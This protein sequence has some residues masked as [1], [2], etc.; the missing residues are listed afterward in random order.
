M[1][2][3]FV[4]EHRHLWPVRLLCAVL[5]ISTSG[6]YAWR[7]SPESRRRIENRALLGDIR[8]VHAESGG[9]YGYPRI[10]AA[11]QSAGRRVGRHRIARLMRSAG[12]RGLVAIPRR[13]RTTDSRHDFPIAPNRLRRNFTAGAPNQVWLA[14]LTYIR[15]GEGWLFLAAL[16]DMYTRKVVGWSMRET[17]HASI[18]LE[19]LRMAVAR[20]RPP[21]G[22]IHHSDLGIQGGFKWSSQHLVFGGCDDF[23]KAA[24]TSIWS[25]ALAVT[26]TA[27]C[28]SALCGTPLTKSGIVAEHGVHH[29]DPAPSGVEP[30]ADPQS[31]PHSSPAFRLT[32]LLAGRG[33]GVR[34]SG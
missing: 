10:H 16:I 32:D 19:A 1:T 11:L 6:Y 20:Q 8:R 17:L 31:V 14:D 2:F 25:G 22:L 23:S 3:G 30:D 28:H 27:A 4:D 9:C 26:R 33:G 29:R 15:T 12:L 7:R 13:V 5:G 21:P 24:V 34:Q 18:A